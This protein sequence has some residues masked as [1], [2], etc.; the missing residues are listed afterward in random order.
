MM[1]EPLANLD[2]PHQADWL[3][4]VRHHVAQGGTAV[5][6]LHEITMALHA[7][8][9][10]VLDGGRLVHQ[11]ACDQGTT[12]RALEQVFEGRIGVRS[13]DGQWLALPRLE[14]P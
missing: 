13:L 12:H 8:D 9:M 14:R 7:D 5:T 6:V 1:D 11:G 3:R 2:P 10:V 4:I